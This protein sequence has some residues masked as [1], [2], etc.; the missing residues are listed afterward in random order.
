VDGR[1]VMDLA[2][3]PHRAQKPYHCSDQG[4][5]DGPFMWPKRTT[6]DI[7]AM[8][9]DVFTQV[10]NIHDSVMNEGGQPVGDVP[11]LEEDE[12]MNEV[13]MEN[14]LQHSTEK[15]FEGSQMNCL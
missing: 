12:E 9:R 3:L 14:L 8:A 7:E 2:R 6:I 4:A 11:N 10:D 13:D 5:E 15:I 1:N